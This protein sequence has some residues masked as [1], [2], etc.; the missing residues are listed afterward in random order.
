MKKR[1]IYQLISLSYKILANV[2]S[3][4]PPPS[5]S[6]TITWNRC[7]S[8][9]D[10]NAYYGIT[11]DSYNFVEAVHQ[12]ENYNAQLISITDQSIDVCAYQ[13]ID[14]NRL[15]SEMILFSGRYIK[16]FDEWAWC[17]TDECESVIEYENWYGKSASVGNC[18]GGYLDETNGE[19]A[20]FTGNYGWVERSCQETLVRVMCRLD[21]DSFPT[22]T[23]FSGTTD[24]PN[25]QPPV[26]SEEQRLMYTVRTSSF[27]DSNIIYDYELSGN[28]TV[29]QAEFVVHT[30]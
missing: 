29:K 12:C 26:P 17:P 7:L 14:Q 6:S 24:F 27:A 11:S 20:N 15:F 18:M 5:T 1:K 9:L 13:T 3:C 30:V 8:S 25:T 4:D 28:I 22:T 16:P 23:E 21:C 2:P 19:T 10:E